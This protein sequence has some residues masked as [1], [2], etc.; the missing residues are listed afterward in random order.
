MWLDLGMAKNL[1]SYKGFVSGF[2]KAP[3]RDSMDNLKIDFRFM[4]KVRPQFIV[5]AHL[6]TRSYEAQDPVFEGS[7]K[8]GGVGITYQR[9]S[10]R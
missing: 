2:I 3:G 10:A 9:D 6:K 8:I 7:R 1:R 5:D 4:W